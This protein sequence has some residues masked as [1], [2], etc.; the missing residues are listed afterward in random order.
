MKRNRDREIGQTKWLGK[1]TI[2]QNVH[3]HFM[4]DEGD[5]ITNKEDQIIQR[6]FLGWL[7][8]HLKKNLWSMPD[9]KINSKGAWVA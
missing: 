6:M 7:T 3:V 8:I 5:D 1:F 2:N 9:A 4:Y